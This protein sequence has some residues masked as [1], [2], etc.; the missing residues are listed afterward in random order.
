MYCNF[1]LFFF[2]IDDA[3]TSTQT[4][5]LC[6]H[7]VI[8]QLP[9]ASLGSW[10]YAPRNPRQ[11]FTKI[12]FRSGC[13]NCLETYRPW[14]IKLPPVISESERRACRSQQT[15]IKTLMVQINHF[16]PIKLNSRIRGYYFKKILFGARR[17]FSEQPL[18]KTVNNCLIPPLSHSA[19]SDLQVDNCAQW[20]MAF[21]CTACIVMVWGYAP[22]PSPVLAHKKPTK[23]EELENNASVV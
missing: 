6:L 16:P 9:V 11:Y 4:V 20:P 5:L 13:P 15:P 7:K 3:C 2:P 19:V 10:G 12:S 21:T 1:I 8:N 22:L 23:A 18:T 17:C 14:E